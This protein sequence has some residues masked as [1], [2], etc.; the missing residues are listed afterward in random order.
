LYIFTYPKGHSILSIETHPNFCKKHHFCGKALSGKTHEL[1]RL[2]M[3]KKICIL[4]LKE[5]KIL[6]QEIA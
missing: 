1:R 4:A 2:K 3:M 6:S 5:K